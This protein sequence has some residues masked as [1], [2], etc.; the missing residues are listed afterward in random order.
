MIDIIN[1]SYLPPP[2][3]APAEMGAGLQDSKAPE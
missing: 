2:S 3:M 1:Q